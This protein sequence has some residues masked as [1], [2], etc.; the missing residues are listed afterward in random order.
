MAAE[1]NGKVALVTGGASGIGRAACIKLAGMG[2]ALVVSDVN[3]AGGGETVGLITKAGGKAIFVNCDVGE[4]TQVAALHAQALN[5]FGALHVA[6]NNAG[7]EGPYQRT[8]DYNPDEF[9]RVLRVNITGVFLCMQQ[10]LQMMAKQGGG[11]IVNIASIAGVAG[12]AYHSAYAA[13]KHAVIGLTK[14]AAL[15]YA[16]KNIRINSVCPGFIQTPMLDET[17]KAQPNLSVDKLLAAVPQ[18]RLGKPEEVAD[19][20]AWLCTDASS[21]ITGHSLLIDG[22]MKSM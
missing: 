7:I 22:G 1:L 11:A 13:S 6:V 16:R 18:A 4:A 21:F 8:A 14:T 20:I 5:H 15:E 3:T 10:Q 17:V 12:F 2:A 9:A 19:A